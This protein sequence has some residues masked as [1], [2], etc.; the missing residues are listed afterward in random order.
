MDAY[1]L[2]YLTQR[3]LETF[4]KIYGLNLRKQQ[5]REH[6]SQ[7][8]KFTIPFDVSKFTEMDRK[9]LTMFN[10]EYTKLTQ[11]HFEKFILAQLLTQFQKCFATSK[12][13]VGKIRV[14]Q[15]HLSK[16][17]LSLRSKEPF[18]FH[19]NYEIEYGTYSIF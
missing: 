6:K 8:R 4:K 19:S 10:F 7:Q 3:M 13:D 18:V 14:E 16:S 11:T 5:E 1:T 15:S 2:T 9:I 12:F 17:P